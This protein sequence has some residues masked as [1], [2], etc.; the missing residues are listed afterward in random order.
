MA[1]FCNK[2]QLW[3]HV[4]GAHG[5]V[6]LLSEVHKDKVKGIE[7]AD[8][9]IWDAHKNVTRPCNCV[10]RYYLKIKSICGTAFDKKEVM[11]FMKRK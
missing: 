6:A 3:F 7:Q 4:D 11:F 10:L 9:V 1:A 2:H 8:S 5:A